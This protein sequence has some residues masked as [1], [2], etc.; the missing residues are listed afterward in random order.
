MKCRAST[1]VLLVMWLAACNY[2]D[3][4]CWPRSE[5]GMGSGVGGGA[6]VPGQGGYGD[7]P[8]EPQDASE[9]PP[10]DCLASAQAE[11]YEKCLAKYE[12]AAAECNKIEDDSQRAICRSAADVAHATCRAGCQRNENDCLEVCKEG[13]D[14]DWERCRDDCPRGDGNCLAEC[15]EELARCYKKCKER[16]KG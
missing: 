12:S 2:T 5:D 6:I 8:P 7:L 9:P 1:V 10:P 16:C 4:E 11:C 14:R 3:G 13:C 15:T